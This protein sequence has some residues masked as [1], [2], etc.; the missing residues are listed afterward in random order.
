MNATMIT[1]VTNRLKKM[2]IKE[3]TDR[4]IKIKIDKE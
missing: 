2:G 1:E 4:P 3:S